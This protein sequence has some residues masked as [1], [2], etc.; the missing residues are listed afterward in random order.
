ML[1]RELEGGDPPHR[2]K[3]IVIEDPAGFGHRVME[4]ELLLEYVL[5]KL[6]DF[7]QA[8]AEKIAEGFE[9]P[10]R[11]LTRRVFT[12][13]ELFWIISLDSDTL[14]TQ[15]GMIRADWRETTGKSRSKEFRDR[16]RAVAAYHKAIADKRAE[17]FREKYGREVQIADAPRAAKKQGKRKSR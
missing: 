10:E 5:T 16:D 14:R 17:G 9:E 7:E 3:L 15:A 4:E 12:T 8:M 11:S 6:V 13:A 1:L 2:C